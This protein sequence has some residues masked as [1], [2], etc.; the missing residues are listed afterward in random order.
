M[1]R[2][3]LLLTLMA[4]VDLLSTAAWTADDWLCKE[5]SSQRRGNTIHACGIGLGADENAA[6]LTAF[7]N[8]E[9]EFL[10]VCSASAD[11]SGHAANADPGR[12][13]CERVPSGFKCY[14]MVVFSI[15]P[16]PGFEGVTRECQKKN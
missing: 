1:S 9:K 8:A 11:C 15:Q 16:I 4:T 10:K 3:I 7:D 14:R 5:A 6:H 2:K 12:T 13:T